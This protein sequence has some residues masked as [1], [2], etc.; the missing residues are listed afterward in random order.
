MEEFTYKAKPRDMTQFIATE[1]K[2]K[3]DEN[4]IDSCNLEKHIKI[5]GLII[6]TFGQIK[7]YLNNFDDFYKIS[8]YLDHRDYDY[9]HNWIYFKSIGRR[10]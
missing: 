5:N 3:A 8:S 7:K 4:Y 2:L 1:D 9:L 10:Y 6:K